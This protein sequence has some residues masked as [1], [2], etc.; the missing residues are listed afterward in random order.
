MNKSLISKTCSE[1]LY[2][3]NHRFPLY[4]NYYLNNNSNHDIKS[5]GFIPIVKYI[6]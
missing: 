4:E 3:L 6:S 1:D 5:N 2:K